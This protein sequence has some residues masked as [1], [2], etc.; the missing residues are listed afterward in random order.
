MNSDILTAKNILINGNFTCVLC[1][2]DKEYHSALRGVKP[3]IDFFESNDSFVGFS[4]ADKVVGAGAAHMYVLLGVKSV[5]ANIISESAKR[6]LE[7]NNI[8]VSYE[9]LVPFIINRAGNGTCPIENA[10]R[11]ITDSKQ[12]YLTIKNTLEEL[13]K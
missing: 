9:N 4:A 11:N 3:L 1:S 13:A 8:S 7:Q 5:W 12:A 2:G 6:I 10:V